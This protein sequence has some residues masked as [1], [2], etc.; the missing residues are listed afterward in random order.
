M[1]QVGVMIHWGLGGRQWE[2]EKI[3]PGLPN[4]LSGVIERPAS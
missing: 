3:N 2:E 1:G 4:D